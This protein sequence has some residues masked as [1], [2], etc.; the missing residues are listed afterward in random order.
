MHLRVSST[1]R[2]DKK[3]W[4]TD[5][6]DC[7]CVE[8]VQR[9]LLGI[10]RHTLNVTHD[11][12][13]IKASGYGFV[14][15]VRVRLPYAVVRRHIIRM[16][17]AK[18]KYDDSPA[19]SMAL[20]NFNYIGTITIFL[21]T[22]IWI[23]LP[24]QGSWLRKQGIDSYLA[25]EDT[26]YHKRYQGSHRVGEV[27]YFAFTL[28]QWTVFMML[29]YVNRIR[30]SLV[31]RLCFSPTPIPTPEAQSREGRIH[32]DKN[33]NSSHV[34]HLGRNALYRIIFKDKSKGA[35]GYTGKFNFKFVPSFDN[36]PTRRGSTPNP[37]WTWKRLALVGAAFARCC[38]N[39]VYWL[40]GSSL[41][42]VLVR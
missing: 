20:N 6:Y 41:P 35:L 30:F 8:T 36:F 42:K 29:S 1:T 32:Y 7:F 13:F 15:S 24:Q 3:L 14:D 19:F 18:P 2:R 9:C 23:R 34:A 11:L 37:G 39:G 5:Y 40:V 38:A 21:A 17:E 31:M 10:E 22:V 27:D 12:D 4:R 33:S 16:V 28:R 26:S 25:P